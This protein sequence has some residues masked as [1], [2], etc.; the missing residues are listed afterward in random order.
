[1]S[2]IFAIRQCVT[3]AL[4][5]KGLIQLRT[6]P[7]FNCEGIAE[8]VLYKVGSLITAKTGGRATLYRVDAIENSYNIGSAEIT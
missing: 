5:D 1:M 3:S 7:V 4:D 6:I 2:I 8:F